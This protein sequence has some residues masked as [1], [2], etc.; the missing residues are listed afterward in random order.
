VKITVMA[1][2]IFDTKTSKLWK[3][4]VDETAGKNKSRRKSNNNIYI[5][6]HI[7]TSE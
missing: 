6:Q 1:V 5:S 3:Y 4:Y 7:I 2:I